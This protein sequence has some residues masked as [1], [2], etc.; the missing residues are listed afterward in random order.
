MKKYENPTIE[1]VELSVEDIMFASK[2]E[3]N[4]LIE[5]YKDGFNWNI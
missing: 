2:V 3:F 4:D 1:V 5:N